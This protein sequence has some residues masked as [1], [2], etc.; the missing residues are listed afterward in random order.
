M[1]ERDVTR[2]AIFVTQLVVN[3]TQYDETVTQPQLV[4]K[5]RSSYNA[6]RE[7][8]E[9][10]LTK[11]ECDRLII[12]LF[13]LDILGPKIAWSNPYNSS[14]YVI[15]GQNAFQLLQ[16]G[17]SPTVKVKFPMGGGNRAGRTNNST[18]SSTTASSAKKRKKN[19]TSKKNSDTPAANNSNKWLSTASSTNKTNAALATRSSKKQAIGKKKPTEIIELDSSTDDFDYLDDDF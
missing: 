1:E 16:E 13:L 7:T 12:S 8:P 11:D 18:P 14:M 5:W 10:M 19:S 6:Q 9:K 4:T 2:H 15:P 17:K 3:M